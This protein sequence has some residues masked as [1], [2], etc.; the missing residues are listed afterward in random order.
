[1]EEGTVS[2]LIKIDTGERVDIVIS[3]A[4]VPVGS[5][6]P[7]WEAPIFE[8]WGM[9]EGEARILGDLRGKGY[10]FMSVQSSI[11]KI[12]D[13]IRVIHKVSPGKRYTI[14]VLKFEETVI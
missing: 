6:L 2:L 4:K 8:E 9:S 13:G 12:E 1:M 3:G 14:T 11:E 10:I 5:V 7:I